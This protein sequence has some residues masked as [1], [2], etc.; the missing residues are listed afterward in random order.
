MASRRRLFQSNIGTYRTVYTTAASRMAVKPAFMG[1]RISADTIFKLVKSGP[2]GYSARKDCP[3]RSGSA[4]GVRWES[5]QQEAVR[6]RSSRTV[7][8]ALTLLARSG[9]GCVIQR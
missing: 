9:S 4:V 2:P 3:D 1:L 7:L 6:I 5:S 8:K